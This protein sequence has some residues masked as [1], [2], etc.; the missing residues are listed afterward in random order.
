LV[1]EKHCYRT[2][3]VVPFPAKPPEI[4]EEIPQ[5]GVRLERTPSTGTAI[6]PFYVADYMAKMLARCPL[7]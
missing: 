5:P 2:P 6:L 4:A 7:A 3:F 1:V